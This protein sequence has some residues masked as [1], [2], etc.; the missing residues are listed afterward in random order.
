MAVLVDITKC[1]GCEGCTV[2]CKRYNNLN[3]KAKPRNVKDDGNVDL[4]DNRWTVI[5]EFHG[6]KNDKLRFVKKQCL[7][8]KEPACA[9]ACFS[10]AIQKDEK[11]GAVVYYPDLCVGCR[12]CLVACPYSIPK[13]QWNEQFP[14][15]SKCQM[16]DSRLQKGDAPACVSACTTGALMSGDRDELIKRAHEIINSDSRYINQVYGEHEV[17]GAEW[18]YISDVPFEEL[19]FKDVSNVPVTSY[20]KSYLSKVPGLAACWALFLSG[21]AYY[22]YRVDKNRNQIHDPHDDDDQDKEG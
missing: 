16:C 5:Q 22:N 15:V 7:H 11:T 10:K 6:E 21:I 1:I 12:Y 3:F 13:Y 18:L 19:G 9:S 17:G 8:C 20:T 4:D 2:A 14:Q